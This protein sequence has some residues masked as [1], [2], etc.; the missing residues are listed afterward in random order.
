VD[1]QEFDNDLFMEMKKSKEGLGR[2][3][4]RFL[5]SK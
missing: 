1:G 4:S 2:K 5:W 3:F